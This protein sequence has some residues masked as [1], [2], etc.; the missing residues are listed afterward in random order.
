MFRNFFTTNFLEMKINPPLISV[1]IPTYNR[2]N[3]LRI[4]LN[5][6]CEQSFKNF[7]V[8]VS[9]DGSTDNTIEVINEF[10][11]LLDLKY[12][13][14]VNF[15][16]PARPRNNGLKLANGEFIAFLDSDDWWYSDKLEVCLKYIHEYDLIYHDL[17]I[18]TKSG[19]SISIAKGRVLK[20]N[21]FHD[22][23]INGNGISN[24]SVLL[25]K[26]IIDLVGEI[27]E[28]KNLIAVEDHDYWIRVASHTQKF[29]YINK[30]FGGYYVAD[31][32]SYSVRQ[33][34]REKALL[35]KYFNDLKLQDQK[36]AISLYHFNSAR[37]Y[38]YQNMY[39]EAS[40]CYTLAFQ[41]SNFYRKLKAVI[42]FLMANLKSNNYSVLF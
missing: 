20:G 23:I 1:I 34:E 15:G 6:L 3:E 22:L 32:I 37:I 2:K 28:D 26:Q 11:E 27:S 36:I 16:G 42:G 19:K 14:D 18:Y 35:D 24:S 12:I 41:T 38:H 21:I 8:I 30:S 25:R 33:I 31:N 39:K 13:Q 17:D 10:K 29:K 7:E 4:C 9:D 5:S 40:K